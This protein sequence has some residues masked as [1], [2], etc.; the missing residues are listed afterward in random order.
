MAASYSREL[1]NVRATMDL[2]R[3]Y[4]AWATKEA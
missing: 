2:E 3:E 1:Q 4:H